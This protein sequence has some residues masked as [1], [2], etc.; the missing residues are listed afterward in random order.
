MYVESQVYGKASKPIALFITFMVSGLAH[1]HV[2][3]VAFRKISPYFLLGMVVQ[4]PLQVISKYYENS[5][6][7]NIIMWVSLFLGQPLLEVCSCSLFH[8]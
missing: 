8:V 7:G 6:F 3:S 1:E 4:V 5:R 2:C